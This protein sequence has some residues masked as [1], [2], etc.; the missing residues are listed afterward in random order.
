MN[1]R[2]TGLLVAL[3]AMAVVAT[4]GE[5]RADYVYSTSNLSVSPAAPVAL[6]QSITLLPNGSVP[7]SSP[8]LAE[9]LSVIYNPIGNISG[10]SQTIS[11]TE[12]LTG[13]PGT[14][15][16]D[17]TGTLNVLLATPNGVLATFT[18]VTTKST[19]GSGFD[20]PANFVTYAS[21]SPTG[22]T[23]AISIG[24]VPVPEPAS[25][26]MVAMGL[27]AVGFVGFRRKPAVA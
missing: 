11:F 3:S 12:T 24:I 17:I 21:T 13:T 26:A 9:V 15:T 6:G 25:L 8:A 7:D 5:A 19:S 23:A 14:Q 22:K 16:F 20:V 2:L 1:F 27:G 4:P 10:F 18:N